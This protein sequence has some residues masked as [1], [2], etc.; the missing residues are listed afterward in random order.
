MGW[1]AYTAG[2]STYTID[3]EHL[4][5]PLP[6]VDGLTVATGCNGSMLS[7]AGGVGRLVAAHVMRSLGMP[8][9][10][11]L[12][13]ELHGEGGTGGRSSSS[14]LGSSGEADA[15]AGAGWSDVLHHLGADLFTPGRFTAARW[16]E[17][18]EPHGGGDVWSEAFRAQCAARRGAKFRG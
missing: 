7:G 4:V 9:P 17:E 5:G 13:V 2:L 10:P 16:A 8:L 12:A 15:A 1:G 3:G 14:S 6:G 18:C 11:P